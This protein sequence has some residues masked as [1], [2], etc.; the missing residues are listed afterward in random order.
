M[1]MPW[2]AGF[3]FFIVIIINIMYLFIY[4]FQ[5]STALITWSMNIAFVSTLV[6]GVPG[7]D[8]KKMHLKVRT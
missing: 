6:T 5:M 4:F 2:D 3:F 1:N 8:N 7:T